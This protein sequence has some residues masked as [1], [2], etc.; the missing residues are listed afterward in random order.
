MSS[1]GAQDGSREAQEDA[2][3]R[4]G[5]PKEPQREPK[6]FKRYPSGCPRG[7]HNDIDLNSKS[8]TNPRLL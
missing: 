3:G 8:L 6:R 5:S 4:N 1:R 2:K 7:D